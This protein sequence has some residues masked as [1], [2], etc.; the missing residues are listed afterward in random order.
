MYDPIKKIQFIL[1]VYLV[2]CCVKMGILTSRISQCAQR[3]LEVCLHAPESGH[4]T[5]NATSAVAPLC[6]RGI[7]TR[8]WGMGGDRIPSP[9]LHAAYR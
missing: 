2:F 5:H 7:C 8:Q 4:V 1:V 3:L 6:Q 9:L